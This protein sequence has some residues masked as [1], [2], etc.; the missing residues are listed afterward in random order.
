[1]LGQEKK[2]KGAG[3]KYMFVQVLLKKPRPSCTCT[4]S[5]S[6]TLAKKIETV[7]QAKHRRVRAQEI[8]RLR[9]VRAVVSIFFG[10]GSRSTTARM[11]EVIDDY[12][13]IFAFVGLKGLNS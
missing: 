7:T 12:P 10:Q 1:M 9:H 11:F 8:T 3:L 4:C 6:T 13:S 5:R 2:L